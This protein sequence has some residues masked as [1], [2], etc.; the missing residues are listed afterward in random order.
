[1]KML[2]ADD[3]FIIRRSIEK[4]AAGL[5][6]EEIFSAPNGKVALDIYKKEHPEVVTL[7]ITMPE[8]DGLAC[9]DEIMKVDPA[10]K[11]IVITALKD[12]A[13]GLTAVRK[14]AKGFLPKPFTAEQIKEEL[15]A[16]IGG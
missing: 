8:M 10:A 16:V 15:I 4:C 14:G 2:V 13:T 11:V 7:D 12:S 3:S 1:M 6:I 9:L 5:G